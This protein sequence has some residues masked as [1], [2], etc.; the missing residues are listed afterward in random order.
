[1]R[2]RF[3]TARY[4]AR[5]PF[6]ICWVQAVPLSGF[7]GPHRNVTVWLTMPDKSN[8]MAEQPRPLHFGKKSPEATAI[9]IEDDTKF[10]TMDGFG[11]ALT[12]TRRSRFSLRPGLLRPGFW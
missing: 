5:I 7:A 3:F 1:M 9:L 12:L 10:Q 2:F 4:L 6:A 8:L 11:H